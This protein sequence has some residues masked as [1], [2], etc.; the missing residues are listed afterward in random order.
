MT[1]CDMCEKKMFKCKNS[2]EININKN[3][4]DWIEHKNILLNFCPDCISKVSK[5]LFRYIENYK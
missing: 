4:K 3:S 1:T 5:F 2:I